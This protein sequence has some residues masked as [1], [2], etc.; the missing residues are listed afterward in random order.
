MHPGITILTCLILSAFFSGVEIAFVSANRLRLE[1]DKKQG[2]F[3]S[4]IVN[5]FIQNP[6]QFIATMLIGNNVVLVIYGI[7]MA[8]ILEP[9]LFQ[10]TPHTYSIL[11]LQTLIST[12]LILVTAEF[13]PK[14]IFRLIP[15]ILLNVLSIPILIFY[16]LLFPIARSIM[17][18]SRLF[19]RKLVDNKNNVINEMYVFGK[20]DLNH[21]FQD[22][23][24]KSKSELDT[25][26][27]IRIFQNALDF[28]NVKLRECMV[29]RTEI[30]AVEDDCSIE[31]L[32][33]K[34]IETGFSKIVVFENSIDNII[35][36]ISSKDLFKNP[37]SLKSKIIKAPIIPG[38]MNASRFLQILLQERKS[39]GIVV[40][41]FGGTSGIVTIEDIME[42]IFGEIEDEHDTVEI[43]EKVLPN[44]EFIFSGKIQIEHLNDKYKLLI[45]DSEEYETLAG[46]IIH[47]IGRLPV[48][49]EEF[50]INHFSFKILKIDN[51]R[52]ELLM[53]KQIEE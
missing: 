53:L 19:I 29:P 21:L 14:A 41:E 30:V 32:R 7:V 42:E 35:G 31:D 23:K 15:N 1:I 44:K 40:D 20:V 3:S 24:Q 37:L 50:N 8:G 26:H 22:I 5:I 34:F 9:L 45:P 49:N 2:L 39:L 48:L 43:I 11:I 51:K 13:L 6:A 52:I 10:I 27:E 16:I 28:S 12:L 33:K 25:E 47:N 38:T 17:W 18:I 36:Y 4:R 46:F